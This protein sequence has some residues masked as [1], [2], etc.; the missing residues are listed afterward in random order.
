MPDVPISSFEVNLPQGPHSAL[1]ENLAKKNK[2]TFCHSSLTMPTTIIAQN[3]ARIAQTTKIAVT[4][5]PVIKKKAK[6]LARKKG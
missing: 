1:T 5:C 3:G 2:G 4:G 6:A